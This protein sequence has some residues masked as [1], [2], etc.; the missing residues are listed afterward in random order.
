M[1]LLAN[2]HGRYL[3]EPGLEELWEVLDARGAVVFVH[4]ADLPGPEVAGVPPFATDFLL[5]TSR[6][7]FLLV[8]NGIRRKYPRVR[9]L[10]SHGGGFVPY[11]SHRMAI[12]IL[13]DTGRSITDSLDE[14][15]TFYFDTALTASPA[16][17][18]TLL[19]FAAPGHITFGSDWPFAPV[20]A[21]IYFATA[22]EDYRG[23]TDADRVAIEWSAA[24]ALFPR[25]G[26]SEQAPPDLDIGLG[27]LV[28]RRLMRVVS[29]AMRT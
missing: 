8:R 12:A 13:G 15:R 29:H 4:P 6:A 22:L 5:D 20:A 23:L 11:A 2:A 14:F 3:G 27:G 17:L 1:T 16:A 24:A 18:P 28:R 7:A 26:T 9:F 10:L 21:G 19:A 25:F